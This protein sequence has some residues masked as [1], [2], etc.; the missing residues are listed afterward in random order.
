M[1]LKISSQI[2][3]NVLLPLYLPLCK[4]CVVVR[5]YADISLIIRCSD[6]Q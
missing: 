6:N 5:L 1:R 4:L 2:R 3:S